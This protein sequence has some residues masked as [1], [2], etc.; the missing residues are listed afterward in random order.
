MPLHAQVCDLFPGGYLLL[1][2][3]LSLLLCFQLCDCLVYKVPFHVGAR[4]LVLYCNCFR[5]HPLLFVVVGEL[6]STTV[7]FQCEYG[8]G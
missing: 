6:R 7:H 8:C 2:Q 5:R 1:L 4:F 3:D